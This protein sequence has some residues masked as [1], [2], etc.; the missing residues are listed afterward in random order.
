MQTAPAST[1]EPEEPSAPPQDAEGLEAILRI[2]RRYLGMDVAF[3]SR[4]REQD[5]LL[6][7]LD[8]ESAGPLHQGQS[9]PLT[10]GYCL[11]VVRGELPQFIPDTSRDA[12][13]RQLPATVEIPIG[14]HLSVP[15]VLSDAHVY[16]TLC[17][18]SYEPNQTLD[19]R[20]VQL[21]RACAEFIALHFEA[22]A[23]R[24]R[25]K[26][27]TAATMRAV[28]AQG[29]PRIVFQP[30]YHLPDLRLHGFECL[31]RFD[32]EP[33]RPPDRWFAAAHDAGVGLD[34]EFQA[35]RNALAY[36]DRIPVG[37]CMN[38]NSSPEMILSGRLLALRESGHDLSRVVLEIT[39]HAVVRDYAA[40]SQ[41]LKPLRAEG[42]TLAVDDAG[43]GYSSMRHI[44][45]LE[46][47]IIKL[48][49]ELTHGIDADPKRKA[50][51]KGLTS[52]A[53]E[54]G[55]LVVA[56]GVETQAELLALA[57]LGVDCAQGYH[58][59][60]PLDLAQALERC[61]GPI[62]HGRCG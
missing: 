43:A 62:E 49:M 55:S 35:I 38:I 20:D 17:C 54:I 30:V 39:E 28:M 48:D 12:V 47:D 34:L 10:E 6:E 36:L 2:V 18:F 33:R 5:R 7:L 1:Q 57:R 26:A 21:L 31:S 19:E 61:R 58:L 59:D 4:F 45:S 9:I 11:K 22:S 37:P 50:L 23:R 53:H 40:L 13:A 44:L 29:A 52:F 32:A 56:E 42:V 24:E 25:D 15:I 3:V 51:A 60:K 8:D 14:S 41:A 16:G 27:Y 46:P